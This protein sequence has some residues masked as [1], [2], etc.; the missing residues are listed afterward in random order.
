MW[1]KDPEVQPVNHCLSYSLS[2]EELVVH[3]WLRWRKL[4]VQAFEPL[5]LD[6][7][8]GLDLGSLA[9]LKLEMGTLEAVPS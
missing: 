8:G 9:R 3:V 5:S 7:I 1:Q 2:F 6:I 4:R